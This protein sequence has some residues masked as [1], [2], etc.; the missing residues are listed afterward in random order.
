MVIIGQPADPSQI[1]DK[2]SFCPG[3]WSDVKQH[4]RRYVK[5]QT[6]KS[7]NQKPAGK[8]Q[9]IT[10]TCANKMLKVDIIGLFAT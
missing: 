6:L 2:L 8:L 3:I 4:A 5:C 1:K 9:E 10:Y 7:D